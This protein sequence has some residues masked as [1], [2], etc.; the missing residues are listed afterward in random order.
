M[1]QLI[2][3]SGV[4]KGTILF[5]IKQGLVPRPSKTH[6][7]MAYYDDRHLEA[8]RLVKEL[9]SKR[10]LPLSVIREVVG[11]GREELSVEE[12]R[13]LTGMDGR[14]FRNLHEQ[15]RV[16]PLPAREL[17]RRT[18]VSLREIRELEKHQVLHPDRKGRTARYA[19]DDIR[20]VECWARIRQA[21]FTRELGFD[22]GIIEVYRSLVRRLV[23]EETLHFLSRVTGRV[24]LEK[25]TRMVEDAAA[26]SNI[27]IEVL[28]KKM[29]LETVRRITEEFRK[30]EAS[31]ESTRRRA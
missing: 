7:N 4:P 13:T 28:H 21:G 5:Y 15:P 1:K 23:E 29:I 9:Q 11:A 27:V 10:F 3:E 2:R 14:L 24:P 16:P 20:L 12:L 30:S 19:E 18:G 6:P 25:V 26:L 31:R 22:P 8:I 17:S